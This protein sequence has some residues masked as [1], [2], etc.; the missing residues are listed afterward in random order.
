VTTG[1]SLRIKHLTEAATG[2]AYP[3]LIEA[4]GR[5]SPEDVGDPWGWLE[6]P[7]T[8][9]RAPAARGIGPSNLRSHRCSRSSSRLRLAEIDRTHRR[10]HVGARP[11]IDHIEARRPGPH[12]AATGIRAR[13]N[14]HQAIGG[15]RILLSLP[16][17]S[18]AVR[19][20]RG[21]FMSNTTAGR[22]PRLRTAQHVQCP[23][24]SRAVR[25]R[26]AVPNNRSKKNDR[27]SSLNTTGNYRPTTNSYLQNKPEKP[28]AFVDA[29]QYLFG[30]NQRQY[31]A[32]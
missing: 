3:R 21:R 15:P 16:T 12:V 13:G 11:H 14:K 10:Q 23:E 2:T 19:S 22:S 20:S 26:S 27:Q 25:G 18:V 31:A 6:F 24:S 7:L 29:G 28:L 30:V 1:N 17:N 9:M 5:C 8:M 4:L 32:L